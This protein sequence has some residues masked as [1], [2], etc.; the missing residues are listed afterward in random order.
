MQQDVAVGQREGVI[1]CAGPFGPN[2]NFNADFPFS[3]AMQA[4]MM[5]VAVLQD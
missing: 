3:G 2:A 1:L 4:I 5:R